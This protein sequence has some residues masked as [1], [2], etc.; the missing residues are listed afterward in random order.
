MKKEIFDQFSV[1]YSN[2]VTLSKLQGLLSVVS[3]RTN[4][5]GVFRWKIPSRGARKLISPIF[6]EF[7]RK[8]RLLFHEG[9]IVLKYAQGLEPVTI[10]VW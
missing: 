2:N 9:M 10:V 3:I 7:E 4:M 5:R 6:I 8:W 1:N